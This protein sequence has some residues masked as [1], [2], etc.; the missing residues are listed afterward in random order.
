MRVT[1]FTR[2]VFGLLLLSSATQAS[3]SVF[4]RLE[5]ID[6]PETLKSTPA[7]DLVYQGEALHQ[8]EAA[9]LRARQ[10]LDLS[11]LDPIPN[12][13][14]QNESLP[15]S[16]AGSFDFPADGV[17][18]DFVKQMDASGIYQAQVLADGRPFRL[19]IDM[20]GRQSIAMAGLLRAMGYQVDTPKAYKTVRVRFD[21][22]ESYKDFKENYN[23]ET[24][25]ARDT[26][27]VS[28]DDASRTVVL[29]DVLLESARISSQLLHTG[30]IA[31]SQ[32]EGSRAKR[33]LL[34]PYTLLDIR[35]SGRSIN[36]YAWE[37]GR[38][39]AE[40]AE[41]KHPYATAFVSKSEDTTSSEDIRWAL[42]RIAKLTRQDWVSIIA[43]TEFPKDIQDILVEK[44]IAR[45]NHLLAM[46]NVA[47]EL[48]PTE[49]VMDYNPRFTSASGVVKKGKLLQKN[50]D[51]YAANFSAGDIPSPLRWSELKHF[52]KMELIAQLIN[53]GTGK[54]NELL[55]IDSPDEAIERHI[56]NQIKD[57]IDHSIKNP[58]EPYVVPIKAWG[59]RIDGLSVNAGRSV[60][61]GTYYGSES[62][63]QLVDNI[64]IGGNIGVLGGIDGIKNFSDKFGFAGSVGYQR[65]YTHVR[66]IQTLSS[67]K[68][69]K[70]IN[71]LV[72]RVM[73]KLGKM[74]NV[75][76]K[77]LDDDE[78]TK[79][80]LKDFLKDIKDGEVFTITDAFV[81]RLNPQINIPLIATMATGFWKKVEP[82]VGVGA[83]N[84]WAI[85]KRLM[86]TRRGE[87]MEIYD[88]KLKTRALGGNIDFNAWINLIRLQA[89]KKKGDADTEAFALDLS[90]VTDTDKLEDPEFADERA[91]LLKGLHHLF[92][93]N[94]TDMLK[95]DFP[96]VALD[97]D[98]VGKTKSLKILMWN[99]A[100]Y[101]ENH[102]VKVKL[103]HDPKH[104]AT[105]AEETRSLYSSRKMKIHGR[106]PYGFVG[107][108]VSRAVD[109]AGLLSSGPSMNP[110][111][112]FLG[113][114][115]WSSVRTEAETTPNRSY[116][117]VI[118][119]EENYAGSYMAPDK[120]VKVLDNIEKEMKPLTDGK[121]LFRRDVLVS[122]R[123]LEAYNIRSSIFVHPDGVQ[124]LKDLFLTAKSRKELMI[125]LLDLQAPSDARS[126]CQKYLNKNDIEMELEALEKVVDDDKVWN[127]C[128]EPWMRKTM[129]KVRKAPKESER[130][131][132]VEWLTDTV[133]FLQ[134]H[135]AGWRLFKRIGTKN[136]LFQIKV[137]GFRHEDEAADEEFVSDTIGN[138]PEDK[139]YG[140]FGD[141]VVNSNGYEWKISDFETNARYFGDGL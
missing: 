90:P 1:H 102:R 58:G 38:I 4:I 89:Q 76:K 12:D 33:A 40:N 108:V 129:R 42:R 131:D 121:S 94:D 23:F 91:K 22:E 43:L 123:R 15:I 18:L 26:W 8:N 141:L 80:L 63:A 87:R 31:A 107:Q 88:T 125:R 20:D 77:D 44:V 11:R 92:V 21:N 68:N 100:S 16:N 66:P 27:L 73:K 54:L 137:A 126:R 72:P 69:E 84:D 41:L 28:A 140:P 29:R 81:L 101:K 109:V 85:V 79:V 105:A 133:Y 35:L 120:V 30:Q 111:G 34:A 57:I 49:A 2:L 60:V 114:A 56:Q 86:I 14:W 135:V 127:R 13:V 17:T 25:F 82:S 134:K 70:W 110:S 138:F 67:V 136:F 103:P 7:K 128:I 24:R 39:F 59:E 119:F 118:F 116:R 9:V 83:T 52:I 132:F 93:K 64:S 61:T 45:R 50:Y 97:H 48:L 71:L 122:T 112:T 115:N 130:E 65:A 95:D 3:D 6:R 10:K 104:N 53:A 74:L 124:V 62:K 78:G 75:K 5:S 113:K 99:W 37:A 55:T 117:P 139:T 19:T 46:F 36:L 98:L 51:G 106:D 32:I 47:P 96:P